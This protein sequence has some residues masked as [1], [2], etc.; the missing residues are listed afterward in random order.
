[1]TP[2]Q[3]R[4]LREL[5]RLHV[6]NPDGFKFT[7]KADL[8]DGYLVVI[9]DLLIGRIEIAEGGLDLR[10]REE[11]ILKVPPDFPFEIP[12][13]LVAHERF[14]T[15]PHVVWSKAL[16][17]YQTKNEWNP[18]DGLYGYFD[19]LK[20]W[21][22]RAAANDMD[23][24]EGPLEPP[25]HV[26]DFSQMP[27]VIRKNAPIPVG[28]TWFGLAELKKYPNRIELLG[29][30]DLTSDWPADRQPA[31]AIFLPQA[32]PME[33]PRKG[34]DFFNELIKQGLGKNQILKDMAL[35]ALLTREGDPIHLVLGIPMRRASD[36]T[37]RFHIA[38]WSTDPEFSK[39]LR[40]ALPEDTDSE[41]LK[42]LRQDLTDSLYTLFENQQIKWCKILENRDEIIVQRDR[43]SAISWFAGKKIL[44][45][46]CGALGS[47]AAEVVARANPNTLHL[48]DNSIV[49]PGF[50]TRQNYT[51]ED[52]G[53]NKAKA[54][55]ARVKAIAPLVA[56]VEGFDQE[57]HA[58]LI[59][60]KKRFNS[61]DMVLDCTASLIF[62]MKLERDWNS[63]NS[64][65][66]QII[67]LIIDAT[68]RRC[69][70]LILEK[71]S[72]GGIWDAYIRLKFK[73]CRNGSD[74]EIIN[75][76]YS[77]EASKDLLQPEPGCS[78][79][80]FVGSTADVSS[81][82]SSALNSIVY[83][84]QQAPV[85]A[86]FKNSGRGGEK[87]SF[88]LFK[89]PSMQEATIDSYRIRIDSNVF[90]QARSWVKQN[91][92]TYSQHHETGGLLWG[93]WD[94]AV[95]SI[96]IFDASGPPPDS[97]HEPSH[98]VCGVQGTVE[99]HDRRI[100]QSF[101]SCG[102]VGFWHTHPDMPSKQS[103]TDTTGMAKLVATVGENQRRAIMFIFGRTRSRPSL[104]IYVYESD[105]R[106]ESTEL[107]SVGEAQINIE[108]LVI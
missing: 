92:R 72:N 46:G 7:H 43:G 93:L 106:D 98:F 45:L 14:K 103:V 4:A 107:V 90:S 79:L 49:K 108:R 53:S 24:I 36:G 85:G 63:F 84:I 74:L 67:S 34:A 8:V 66:P 30:N 21:L 12:S 37:P 48:V 39:S 22:N 81:L 70:A 83:Q 5:K 91:I 102:F 75:A 44:I 101:G 23:P 88:E 15:F 2:G 35:A 42:S 31:L 64:Q 104:G 89:L 100:K 13:V 51:L 25:H 58:F 26:T 10:E 97:L 33:F 105:S 11:F 95:R 78:D 29:W 87:G 71:K 68:A 27:F 62:Q 28:Q 69:L 94:D 32:L 17:L 60:D 41:K 76:F 73:I 96:W 18:S 77:A 80:T 55:V 52:I 56:S 99:E 16:C 82:M 50:L 65:T 59:A 40:L 3:A 57:A 38:V 20:L 54:L 6:T 47:W 9:L 61:Y 1:M 86:A 19:R